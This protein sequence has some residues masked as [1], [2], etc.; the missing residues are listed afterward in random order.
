MA[1]QR[2]Y[3]SR[4][5]NPAVRRCPSRANQLCNQQF[6]KISEKQSGLSRMTAGNQAETGWDVTVGADVLLTR[7]WRRMRRF[8]VRKTARYGIVIIV[9]PRGE[10][11][12]NR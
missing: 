1:C 12:F 10:R 7:T 9:W 3:I 5:V 11:R 8:P 2:Q 4:R 6:G